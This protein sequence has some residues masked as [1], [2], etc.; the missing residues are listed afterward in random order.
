MIDIDS[1]PY[2]RRVWFKHSNLP[3]NCKGAQ[4]GDLD[5]TGYEPDDM[6]HL[7]TYCKAVLAGKVIRAGGVGLI[8]Q[9]DPGHGKTLLAGVIAS[10]I[11]TCASL[12]LLQ[13]G[14]DVPRRPV[15]FTSFSDLLAA[16]RELMNAVDDT[17][18]YVDLSRITTGVQGYCNDPAWNVQLLVLDDVGREHASTTGWTE[19]MLS[20]LLRT[21]FEHGLPTIITTNLPLDDDTTASWA[22]VYGNGTASLLKQACYSMFIVNDN[23]DL[24][25]PA[26]M[27]TP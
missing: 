23:G 25:Q 5:L 2:L 24:R 7:L 15:Y 3:G 27:P 18:R 6:R 12:E 9:G 21:R 14:E 26:E 20:D 4:F 19:H 17:D 8:L 22:T 10:R 11:M 16:K 1:L 13:T